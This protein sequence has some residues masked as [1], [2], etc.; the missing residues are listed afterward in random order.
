MAVPRFT[1]A[2][3]VCFRLIRWHRLWDVACFRKTRMPQGKR[4][5]AKGSPHAAESPRRKPLG[6]QLL[7]DPQ[8]R[9]ASG[10]MA[11]RKRLGK[12]LLPESHSPWG[13][14]PRNNRTKLPPAG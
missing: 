13:R 2:T 14:K 9:C 7:P 5:R 11:R 4:K 3:M 12:Q 8:R 6:K 1:M 10:L